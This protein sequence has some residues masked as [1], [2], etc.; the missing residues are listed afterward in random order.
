MEVSNTKQEISIMD[1][2]TD[3]SSEQE[4]DPAAI[5][6]TKEEGIQAEVSKQTLIPSMLEIIFKKGVEIPQKDNNFTPLRAKKVNNDLNM[7]R[8]SIQ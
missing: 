8:G 5:P 2:E 4:Q 1:F 3:R 6:E 7:V